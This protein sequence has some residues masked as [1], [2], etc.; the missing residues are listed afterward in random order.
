[1]LAYSG[2]TP[3][4]SE[5]LDLSA[6]IRGSADAL[7]PLVVNGSLRFELADDLEPIRGDVTQIGQILANLVANAAEAI[8]I[9]GHV[10]VRTRNHLP[11]RQV[12][13][14]VADDGRGMD[15]PTQKNAFD[16][17]LLDQV[18]R[19]WPRPRGGARQ[20]THAQ[21]GGTQRREP[22]LHHG[23]TFRVSFPAMSTR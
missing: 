8:T 7:L 23:A 16:P 18:R 5:V 6:V 20:R 9:G 1:M 21:R 3:L 2:R 17:V 11:T 14:E 22:R 4:R 13:L 10:V 12:I 19:P 15:E